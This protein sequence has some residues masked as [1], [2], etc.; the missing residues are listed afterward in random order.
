[1]LGPPFGLEEELFDP[2]V[3]AAG[4]G[5]PTSIEDAYCF[6]MVRNIF[7][8]LNSTSGFGSPRT[9]SA[10]DSERPGR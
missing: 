6:G 3:A 2:G 10:M 7:Y 5:G 8:D 9:P 1:M 4:Q